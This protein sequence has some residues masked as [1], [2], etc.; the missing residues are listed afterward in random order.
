MIGVQQYPTFRM[1][2]DLLHQS[3]VQGM[4]RTIGNQMSDKGETE[5]RE[6]ADQVQDFVSDKLVRKAEAGF[7]DDAVAG[8][9]D[10][11]VEISAT[12]QPASPECFH[13]L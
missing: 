9:N 2:K 4:S 8:K 5:E 10:G 1:F 7:I 3:G 6:V 12:T 11:V 13:F